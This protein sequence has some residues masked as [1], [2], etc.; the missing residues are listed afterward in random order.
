V[1]TYL[2]QCIAVSGE[3]GSGSDLLKF[4]IQGLWNVALFQMVK[5]TF[6]KGILLAF[7]RT[8]SAIIMAFIFNISKFWSS[9]SKISYCFPDS[10][11]ILQ[12]SPFI[13][14]KNVS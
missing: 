12:I 7:S 10:K 11:L 8:S 13:M 1:N 4:L 5:A 2:S 6:R 9:L 3:K 14:T